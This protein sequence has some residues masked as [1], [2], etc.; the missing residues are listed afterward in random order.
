MRAKLLNSSLFVL[1]SSLK[2][3]FTGHLFPVLALVDAQ[4]PADNAYDN[5]QCDVHI[6]SMVDGLTFHPSEAAMLLVK[7]GVRVDVSVPL[8]PE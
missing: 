2:S 1:H 7:L 8:C 6:A 4:H 5:K 3:F